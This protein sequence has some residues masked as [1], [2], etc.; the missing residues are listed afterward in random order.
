MFD[1]R[2][3]SLCLQPSLSCIVIDEK[4]YTA[5]EGSDRTERHGSLR[6]V[7]WNSSPKLGE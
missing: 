2:C 3:P 7:L 4:F 5:G 1:F 6:R